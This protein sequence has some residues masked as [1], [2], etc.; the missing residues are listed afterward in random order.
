M[1]R[2]EGRSP[3]LLVANL[4]YGIRVGEAAQLPALYRAF[5]AGLRTHFGGWRVALLLPQSP[6]LE[7]ALG[8]EPRQLLPLQNGGI[9]CWLLLAAL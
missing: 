7:D 4:P 9:A 2:P 6:P 8:L 3:G 1:I 5:G